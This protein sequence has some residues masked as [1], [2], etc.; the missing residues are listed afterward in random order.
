M[1]ATEGESL[2]RSAKLPI[3][4]VA[5]LLSACSAAPGPHSTVANAGTRATLP[6]DFAASPSANGVGVPE[7]DAHALLA[8]VPTPDDL[9]AHRGFVLPALRYPFG[10]RRK[11]WGMELLLRVGEDGAVTCYAVRDEFD[12]PQPLDDQRRALLAQ[13][14]AWRYAPFLRDG[15]A[16][17]ALV[18]EHIAEEELP[19]RH[20]D[21][22]DVPLSD[23]RIGLE[24]TGCFG[25]CPR[26]RV[27]LRGDGVVTYDGDEFV[28]VQGRHAYHVPVQD[29]ARLLDTARRADLWSLRPAYRSLIT[30]NPT[31]VVTLDMG[32]QVH[33]IADYVGQGVGMPQAVADFEKDIDEASRAKQ[34]IHLGPQAVEVLEQEGFSFASSAGASLLA[35]A[36]TDDESDDAALLRLL[37]LG[38]PIA[39]GRGERMRLGP[40]DDRPLVENALRNGHAAVYPSL[41]ALGALSTNGQPDPAKRDAAFRAAIG[42][43]RLDGVRAVWDLPAGAHPSLVYRDAGD[44]EHPPRIVPVTLLLN[45]YGRT[46]W[47][48]R[49]VAQWL[50]AHGC[51]P[52]GSGANGTTLLHIAADAGDVG[53]VRDVLALGVD[54]SAHG[55]FDLPPLGSARNEDVAMAL[56]EAGSETRSLDDP[57][58]PFRDY[59]VDQ[60]WPRVVD[61]LD[62][63]ATH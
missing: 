32:G 18:T 20:V 29:V 55:E 39:G 51:D 54:P 61:W 22:P 9:T 33:Q 41:V 63:H 2:M 4:F 57:R 31:Y 16:E 52:R 49:Q 60:H 19:E 21:L 48:G 26:Y 59:A 62:R 11:T 40:G 43:G 37:A 30:D 6:A 7:C 17:A 53:F 3:L 14:V 50:I 5:L 56:L 47:E 58:R 1:L 44:D 25:T 8:H 28:S 34:W 15:R 36:A 12:R 23:V 10:A 42:G 27:E 13:L 46:S 45:R 35:R 24:R 38:T